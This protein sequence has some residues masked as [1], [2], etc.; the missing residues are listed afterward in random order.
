LKTLTEGSWALALL[1]LGGAL[2]FVPLFNVLGYEWCLAVAVLAAVAGAHLG[3]VLTTRARRLRAPAVDVR[4]PGATVARLY[5]GVVARTWLMMVA[6]LVVIVGNAA[7]VRNCDLAGGLAWFVMLPLA[8][9]AMGAALG[10]VVGLARPWRRAWAPSLLALGGIVGSIVWALVRYYRTPPISAYDPFFGYFA[11]AL[12]DEDVGIGAA[13]VWARLYQAALATTALAGCALLLDGTTLALRGRAAGRRWAPLALTVAAA[14]FALGL[15]ARGAQLR[16]ALDADDVAR[17]LGGE[18][19]TAHC[20]LHYSPTGPYASQIDAFAIDV[21][22]RWAQ[23]ARLFARPP[24]SPIHLFLFDSPAQKRMLVGASN[25]MVTKGWRG[26]TYLHYDGWPQSSL[27]HELAHVFATSFGD[28]LLGSSHH[29]IHFNIGLMEGVAVAAAWSEWEPWQPLSPHQIVEVLREAKVVEEG[30]LA[31]VMGPGFY[32]LGVSEAYAIAGSFCRFLI[33][34]RGADKLMAIHRVGGRQDAWRLIYGVDFAALDVEWRRFVDG[35]VVS[36]ADR[37]FALDWLRRPSV[38]GRPCAHA[39]AVERQQAWQ[40]ARAGDRAGALARWRAVCDG[41]LAEPQDL[42]NASDGALL[43]DDGRAARRFATELLARR[44]VGDVLRGG[45]EMTLGDVALLDEDA[46]AAALAYERA[47]RLPKDDWSARMLALK[48]LL[49][50]WP[51][52]PARTTLARIVIL[53]EREGQPSF[54]LGELRALVEREPRRALYRYLLARQLLARDR[55]REVV[56]LLSDGRTDEPLPAAQ[57]DRDRQRILGT[58]LFRVGEHD[59]ARAI[60]AR[61]AQDSAAEPGLRRDALD[62]RDRCDFAAT[63]LPENK[64]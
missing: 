27:A 55:F 63:A 31:R 3:A 42:A 11:G 40:A 12:Y 59:G 33:D 30:A 52:G 18:K 60:F 26:E 7:R 47:A 20:V 14:G 53:A 61:L 8:S 54:E 58:A 45:A 43:A 37:A 39:V 10:V 48:R 28:P 38:F 4:R 23:H 51:R 34:T 22:F 16:F 41:G 15:H 25:T 6:P 2:C 64:R 57:F 21:E 1:V 19:R 50:G 62:W 56:D 13:L 9:A 46:G 35:Q 49:S 17:A 32:E 44:D 29:G 24:S 5:A 36:A